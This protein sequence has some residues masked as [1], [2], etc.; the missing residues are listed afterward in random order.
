MVSAYIVH[1][2]ANNLS[3]SRSFFSAVQRYLQKQYFSHSS[4]NVYSL[5]RKEQNIAH[6]HCIVSFPVRESYM[7]TKLFILLVVKLRKY[8]VHNIQGDRI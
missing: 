3:L 8:A 4:E 2:F 5:L 7:Y 1:V 6:L